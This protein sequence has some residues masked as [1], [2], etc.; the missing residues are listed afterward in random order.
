MDS[1]PVLDTSTSPSPLARFRRASQAVHATHA[2]DQVLTRTI[3]ELHSALDAEAATVALLDEKSGEIIF[4]A[5]GP[6]AE[7]LTGLQVPLGRGIVGWVIAN[8]QSAVVN[9]VLTDPRFW[10]EV[11]GYSGFETH[12]VLCAPLFSGDKVIG[13]LQVLNKHQ[14][15]F[16]AEDLNFLEAFGAVAVSAIENA[17]RF[18][19]EQQRRRQADTLRRVWEALTTP[20]DLDTLLDVILDQLRQ[21]VDYCSAAILFVTEDGNL[22]LAASS[23][24]DDLAKAEQVARN[25]GLDVKVRTML[26][27]RQPLLISDTRT[28]PRWRHFPNMSYVRSW[29]GAP[30]FIKGHLVGTLNVDHD[31]AGQYT[32]DQTR[33]LTS[34]AH[35]AAIAIENSQLYAATREAT[36]Q[37]A[38]QARRL[39]TLYETSRS[40]LSGLELDRKALRELLDRITGLI[41][42]R[43]G[44]LNILAENSRPHLLVTSGFSEAEITSLDLATLER[45]IQDVL[46]G[47]HEVICSDELDGAIE[48]WCSLPP[49]IADNYLGVAI[50]AR[51]YTSGWLLLAGKADER[52]FSQDDEALALALA[53]NLASTIENVS[54]YHRTQQRLRELSV[55]YE[56]SRTVTEVKETSEAYTLLATQVARVLDVE[57]CIFFIYKDGEMTC[58]PPGYGIPAAFIPQFSF[59][60]EPD[61]PLYVTIHTPGTLFNN[62]A[63]NDEDLVA[64]RT[65]LGRLNIRRILSS[66]IVI[67]KEQVGF[68]VAAD[69]RSGEEFSEQDRRLVSIITQQVGGALQRVLL[70]S[71]QQEHIQTQSALLKVSQATSSLINLDQLL[72][73]VAQITHQ[74]MDSDHCFIASWE[75]RY[76]AFVPRAQ[77]GLDLTLNE[78][79]PHMLLRPDDIPFIDQL[80]RTREPVV[81]ARQDIVGE[82]PLDWAQE[83]LGREHS[84]I[85]P[86][87]IQ[88]RIVGLIAVAY[89]QD[90]RSPGEKEIALVTGIAHQAAVAI[91]NV[92]L[93]QE[94]QLHSRRLERAYHDLKELDRQKT[95]FI[96]NVSHELR[97][98]FTLVEGYLEMLVNEEMGD[99]NDKQKEALT[100]VTERTK[101]LDQVIDD[102]VAIQS[103]DTA[104]LERYDLDLGMVF[105]AAQEQTHAPDV[106][107]EVDSPHELPLVKADPNLMGR[108]VHHLLSNAIKFSPNGGTI[109][110]RIRLE[111][112]ML[113]AEIQDEGIGIS[114]EALPFVFDR[115]Y[116]AD[117]STTRQFGGAGLGLA[118]VKQIVEA[119]GG[120]IGVHSAKGEGSTFYFRLPLA[121]S[122]D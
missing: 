113:Y 49:A 122:P 59:S 54:L 114:S 87:A 56:I 62:D 98:P 3:T 102:I 84:L 26:E 109:T 20:R 119:H 23:G 64:Q 2:L 7:R 25:L 101:A 42:A 76:A 45:D 4:Y 41:G 5:A 107:I 117:G 44:I 31:K 77:S 33:L 82:L 79:L 71:H 32:P 11:D 111:N 99:L 105:R 96:Q 14:G 120:Q 75:E 72:Q 46:N 16:A 18:R 39:V 53:A 94:L 51:G 34:F 43:Y 50:H 86:L 28:D 110:M 70:Q 65:M 24:F 63:M 95:Q 10:P 57:R 40:L 78:T 89:A 55:L 13:A 100:I 22:E 68:L 37:L 17:R 30:L 67:D 85:V 97:T 27:T 81:L 58:Q 115:F 74:L 9:D 8:G 15:D 60:V 36:L 112:E 118:V 69:K 38:E 52:P 103:V 48:A 88:K 106:R 21:L 73:T 12:S 116:Q 93:Y 92:S 1:P 83:L 121:S 108:A 66:R 91:E 47:E 29:M 61:D 80:T 104:S 90:G 35:Q 6:V 19:Q